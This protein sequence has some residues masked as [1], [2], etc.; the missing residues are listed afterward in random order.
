MTGASALLSKYETILRLRVEHEAALA[1]SQ[2]P[3]PP[4]PALRKLAREFP[5][6]LAEL[7]RLPSAEIRARVD[8]LRR[9]TWPIWAQAWSDVHEG[10][11]GVLAAKRW[12]GGRRKAGD[13]ERAAL[14]DAIARGEVH[15]S[16]GGWVV[17]LEEIAMPPNGRLV[18][19]VH[20]GVAAT[21][22]VTVGELDAILFKPSRR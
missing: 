6:A 10:L 21:L 17:R 12:L 9:G 4:L 1:Q 5:G 15:P 19:L 16:A 11:R 14:T 18:L 7:E 2:R 8:E 22:G 20:E 13:S 3:P